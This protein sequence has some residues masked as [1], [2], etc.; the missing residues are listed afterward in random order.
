MSTLVSCT[1]A[2]VCE[3]VIAWGVCSVTRNMQSM[4]E[5][6][7]V[8]VLYNPI[9]FGRLYGGTSF[10]G[11]GRCIYVNQGQQ[12]AEQVFRLQRYAMENEFVSTNRV[13]EHCIF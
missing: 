10:T 8:K 4:L 12:D 13:K 9:Q 6:A 7:Y 5:E 3:F 11:L 1:F 2:T